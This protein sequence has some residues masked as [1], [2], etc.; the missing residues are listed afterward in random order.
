ME[1][2]SEVVTPKPSV[3]SEVK[4]SNSVEHIAMALSKVQSELGSVGKDQ[5]GYGYNYSSL[6]STIEVSKASLAKNNLAISQLVGN[7]SNGDPSVTT[8]LL[9]GGSGQYF[10]S[11][12]SMPKV[13]MKGCN[14]AQESGATLSYL[15]RYALQA[16]LN[17]ASEDN[18][19]SSNGHTKD[20]ASTK[21]VKPD[22]PSTPSKVS[23]PV[24][25]ASTSE[26][27]APAPTAPK[28]DAPPAQ[29]FRRPRKEVQDDI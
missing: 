9:H 27:K 20:E 16:L 19:A 24:A 15:R 1:T 23:P 14:V 25:T 13:T 2:S 10:M 26:N 12:A 18:D 3:L 4:M 28:T 29:K 6:A 21:F 8:I 5:K 11:T 17:M 22:A 7:S